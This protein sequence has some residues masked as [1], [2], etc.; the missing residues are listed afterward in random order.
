MDQYVDVNFES[1]SRVVC[2]FLNQQD[3]YSNKSCTITLR[4]CEQNILESVS[5][6]GHTTSNPVRLEFSSN[7]QSY[8]YTINAS[9]GTFAVL[10]EGMYNNGK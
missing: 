9:N 2:R 1:A 5:V 8:C 7:L 3:E 10:I 6:Q 4:L